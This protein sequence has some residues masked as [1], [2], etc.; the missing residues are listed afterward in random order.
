[1]RRQKRCAFLPRMSFRVSAMKTAILVVCLLALV[2]CSTAR[3]KL[4]ERKAFWRNAL[5]AEVPVGSRK[6]AIEAWGARHGVKFMYLEKKQWL[7]AN[8]ER[9]PE[10][11]IPFPCSDWNIIVEIPIGTEGQSLENR[12][13]A[14][15]SFV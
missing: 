10:E 12:V 2:G 13:S 5:N 14:V 6:G 1:M 8:V 9:I 7:Y 15:G 11:G 3:Q 4:D